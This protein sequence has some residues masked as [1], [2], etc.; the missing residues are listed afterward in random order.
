[1]KLQIRVVFIN[2]Y[3]VKQPCT[4]VKPPIEDFLAM[5]LYLRVVGF[6]SLFKIKLKYRNRMDV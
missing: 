5:V 6:S 1:M 4:N 3:N 2:F